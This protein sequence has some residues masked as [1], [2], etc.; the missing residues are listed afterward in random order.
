METAL[1]ES[2]SR[3]RELAEHSS[4]II[5]QMTPDGTAQYISDS[6]Q[7]LLGYDPNLIIGQTITKYIHP[8]D[9]PA[10]EEIMNRLNPGSPIVTVQYRIRHKLGHYEWFEAN[11][12]G[13]FEG[14]TGKLTQIQTAARYVTD[15]VEA[16]KAL[17]ASEAKYKALAQNFPNGCVMLFNHDLRYTL[18]DGNGLHDMNLAHDQLEGYTIYD[19][20]PPEMIPILETKYKAVLDGGSAVFEV[21]DHE[22]IIEYHALPVRNDNGDILFGMVMT[23]DV[24]ERIRAMTELTEQANYLIHLNEITKTALQTINYDAALDALAENVARL[25]NSE[26]CL[27]VE[28][29]EEN[30][31]AYPRA[32]AGPLKNEIME[33]SDKE[34]RDQ[35]TGF[36]MKTFKEIAISDTDQPNDLISPE[37]AHRLQSKSIMCLP[38]VAASQKLG[39]VMVGYQ[40]Q[41]IFNAVDFAHG[42]QAAAQIALSIHRAQLFKQA[43]EANVLLENRVEERTRDLENKNRELET[44]TYS[45][46]HDLKAPLR[47]ISGYSRLLMED[48]SQ[49][50]DEEGLKFLQTICN[51]TEQMN[52]LIEDLLSYTRLE[53]SSMIIR[54]VNLYPLMASILVD[55]ASE[56]S[57]RRIKVSNYL[58]NITVQVDE[59]AIRQVLR[60]LI[61]NAIKFTRIVESPEIE[62]TGKELSHSVILSI[63]DNGIGFDMKYHDRIFDI[64]QRLNP[65]D[66]YPGTGI[67]L[68][69]VK[70]MMLRIGGKVWAESKPGEGTIFYLEIPK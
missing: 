5:I 21:P 57:A 50:L 25:F 30:Q 43:T 23:Q 41:H 40:D 60:N 64:F 62:I 53:K 37:I 56:T 6:C 12:R 17:Q 59:K 47:G 39:A 8:D 2:E 4:D 7:T 32:V 24:T 28:W 63:R 27:I 52:E 11:I 36:M 70:K 58:P 26:H 22:R 13:I 61:D 65:S 68:A 20:Y 46:S 66:A 16:S 31:K 14:T 49:Q 54:P 38:L 10:L 9:L 29:D 15:R 3:F 34:N 18:A 19:L 55:S 42:E 67:G 44:F 1:R 35:I 48:H 45:V 69:I 33:I 51:S